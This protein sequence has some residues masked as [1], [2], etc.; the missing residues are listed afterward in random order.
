M[1]IMFPQRFD[2]FV[3]TIKQKNSLN[4]ILSP[5]SKNRLVEIDLSSDRTIVF[6]IGPEAGFSDSEE[7]MASKAEFQSVKL[8]KRILRTETVAVSLLS[9][10]N[11]VSGEF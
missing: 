9:I 4:L 3:S 5:T 6:L 2:E 7:L 11:Y 1:K 8:G 10:L